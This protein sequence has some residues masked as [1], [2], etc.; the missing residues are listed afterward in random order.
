MRANIEIDD[1]L[2]DQALKATG[3][4]GK[5]EVVELVLKTL[6]QLQAQLAALDLKGAIRWDGN[7]DEIRTDR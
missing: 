5:R 1:Q 2:M 6:V 7:L 3:A 4:K